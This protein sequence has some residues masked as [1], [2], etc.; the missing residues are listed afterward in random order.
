MRVCERSD[1]RAPPK[2]AALCCVLPHPC[3]RWSDVEGGSEQT[4][5][6]REEMSPAPLMLVTNGAPSDG[7]TERRQ[8]PACILCI[9]RAPASDL[10]PHCL[11]ASS[12]LES[13]GS[14]RI[15]CATPPAFSLLK[16]TQSRPRST[17]NARGALEHGAAPQL[18]HPLHNC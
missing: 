5:E 12:S 18:T 10:A 15:G 17:V 1:A 8:G 14:H 3:L 11:P 13:R 4:C 7:A 9:R 2:I 16:P 6:Q